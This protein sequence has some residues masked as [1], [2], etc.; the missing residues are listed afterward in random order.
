MLSSTRIV[1]HGMTAILEAL[2]DHQT[3]SMLNPGQKYAT[4]DPDARF[5]RLNNSRA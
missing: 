2:G 4:S 1:F 3:L 5:D